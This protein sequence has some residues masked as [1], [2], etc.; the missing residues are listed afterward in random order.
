ME[1]WKLDYEWLRV[2]HIVKEAMSK[3]QLPDMNALLFL[4]GIQELGFIQE[5]FT[6]EEKQDLMHIAIC[7]LLEP[8][9][10]FEFEGYDADGWPHYKPKQAFTQSGVKEQEEILKEKII[11]YFR[12]LEEERGAFT[13]Q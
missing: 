2:R 7:R 8:E 11:Y 5:E 13:E 3:E 10:Y 12:H 6:K 1:E 9:G 4:I